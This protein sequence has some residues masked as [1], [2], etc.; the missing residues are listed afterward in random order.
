MIVAGILV[1]FS[2][3][4]KIQFSSEYICYGPLWFKIWGTVED[5]RGENGHVAALGSQSV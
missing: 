2:P 4:I 1:C 3:G 5:L